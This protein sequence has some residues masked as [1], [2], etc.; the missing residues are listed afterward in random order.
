MLH[1]MI[2]GKRASHQRN[3]FTIASIHYSAI[4]IVVKLTTNKYSLTIN[5]NLQAWTTQMLIHT[6][7]FH[8]QNTVQHV[9]QF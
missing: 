2:Q 9:P 1:V 8:Q 4:D 3:N 5:N 7:N 6:K